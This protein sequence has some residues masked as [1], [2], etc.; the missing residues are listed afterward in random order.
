MLGHVPGRQVGRV[1]PLRGAVV[2][3][4]VQPAGELTELAV[5]QQVALTVGDEPTAHPQGAR[6][7]QRA[8]GG[9]VDLRPRAPVQVADAHGT[10]L[11]SAQAQEVEL[12]PHAED[13]RGVAGDRPLVKRVEE[14]VLGQMAVGEHPMGAAYEQPV[15]LR[16]HRGAARR[17]E[18]AGQLV[19]GI[20]AL[21]AQLGQRVVVVVADPAED[22]AAVLPEQAV[23]ALLLEGQPQEVGPLLVG[24]PVRRGVG[25]TAFG[26]RGCGGG[27]G[28]HRYHEDDHQSP[29]RTW[30]G[31]VASGGRQAAPPPTQVSC[32][33]VKAMSAHNGRLRS[34]LRAT[35]RS[36]RASTAAGR[37]KP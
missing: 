2:A 13:L 11:G 27:Q 24:Q 25:R 5:E 1:A 22:V 37:K 29:H 31:T 4:L 17:D 6:F 3:A 18:G 15:G 34:S 36:S 26:A 30:E 9:A 14:Q 35:W 20:A 12:A 23:E 7:A 28:E 19:G 32:H 33:S 21:L 8:C 10:E 16:R